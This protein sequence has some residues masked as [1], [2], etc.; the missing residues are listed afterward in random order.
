MNSMLGMVMTG[1]TSKP[2]LIAVCMIVSIVMVAALFIIGQKDKNRE[3]DSD[4]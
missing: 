4:E 3:E 1:D 2:W